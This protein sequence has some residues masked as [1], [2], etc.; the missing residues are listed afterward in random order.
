MKYLVTMILLFFVTPASAQTDW[1]N[2]PGAPWNSHTSDDY[3]RQ[4]Q[5]YEERARQDEQMRE[6]REQIERQQQQMQQQQD[7]FN[8]MSPAER[9][10]Y[11]HL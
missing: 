11:G 5:M 10:T 4:N 3:N 1:N 9:L 2:E 8:N 6:Q 7:R